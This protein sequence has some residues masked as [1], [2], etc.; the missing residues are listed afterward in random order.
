MSQ[1]K[2]LSLRGDRGPSPVR[3]AVWLLCL[4]GLL[5]LASVLEFLIV[6]GSP[7]GTYALNATAG[8]GL[9]AVLALLVRRGYRWARAAVWIWAAVGLLA[10][11]IVVAGRPWDVPQVLTVISALSFPVAVSVLLALPSSNQYFRRT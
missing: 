8:I 7:N 1:S 6:G 5:S 10:V 4:F 2:T 9:P 11:G 3:W